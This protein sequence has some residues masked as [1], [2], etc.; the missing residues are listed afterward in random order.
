MVICVATWREAQLVFDVCETLLGY[1]KKTIRLDIRYGGMDNEDQR[2]IRLLNGCEILVATVPSI[3]NAIQ[4]GYTNLDRLCHLVFDSADKLV[5]TFTEDIKYLMRNYSDVLKANDKLKTN[6]LIAMSKKWSYGIHSLM[7]SYFD[8]EDC[9]VVIS[10]KVEAALFT[11]IPIAVEVCKSNDRLG[12]VI[13]KFH[14]SACLLVK[15][16]IIAVNVNGRKYQG[17]HNPFCFQL[18]FLMVKP[19]TNL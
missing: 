5:E 19:L 11:K 6:Q 16:Y 17:S 18:S 9:L 2:N 15:I 7:N 3:N 12:Y 10:N 4:C 14:H 13:G 1:Y 8:P